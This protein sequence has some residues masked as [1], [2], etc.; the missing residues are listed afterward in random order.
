MPTTT[1]TPIKAFAHC[2]DWNC[3]GM[4]QD[5]VDG[6]LEERHWTYVELGGDA[7]G[8]ERSQ[9]VVQFANPEERDCP[10]CAGPRDITD[11]KRPKYPS[12]YDPDRLIELL[13]QGLVAG[14][15]EQAATD[16]SAELAELKAQV[17]A[18]AAALESKANKP[19]P[20]PKAE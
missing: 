3:K 13:R 15:G 16:Q 18:L 12:R 14:P 11:Q 1:T 6:I 9:V 4:A 5:P 8:Y 17:A 7:P 2:V 10:H 19:G 20:K